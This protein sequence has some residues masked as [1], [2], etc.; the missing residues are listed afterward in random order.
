MT[1]YNFNKLIDRTNTN[2]SKW[3]ML[4]DKNLVNKV[5]PCWIADMDFEMLLELKNAIINRLECPILGYTDQKNELKQLIVNWYNTRYNYNL[6]KEQIIITTGVVFSIVNAINILTN[7]NDTI[8]LPTPYYHRF[9]DS[10]INSNRNI[11]YTNMIL[12]NNRYKIDYNTLRQSINSSCKAIII[13]NPH[14]PTGTIYSKEE[15]QE[16]VNFCKEYNLKIISDEI[17]C[18]FN[19]NNNI[20]NMVNYNDYTKANAI[21]LLSISKT[22]N[23]ASFKVGFCVID[24]KDI[25]IKFN[26]LAKHNGITSINTF[27]L[28]AIE[29]CLKYG[30]TYVN[31]LNDYILS[32]KEY[33]YKYIKQYMPNLITNISEATY[34]IWLNLNSICNDDKILR[35]QLINIANI[36]P[37][38]GSE[39][40]QEY[41]GYIRINVACPNSQVIKIMEGLR[42]YYEQNTK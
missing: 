16:L 42:N 13:C 28:I 18:D 4:E 25:R 10:I 3:A 29:T 5:V 8:I 38:M 41:N 26:K 33:C 12:D 31:E 30:D 7:I 32:N 34:L 2:A 23:C 20:I 19:F 35:K 36:L 37:S 17:H 39:F 21:S 11:L 9:K 22:F 14:N 40:G 1:K 27:G 24:N 15:I 6:N